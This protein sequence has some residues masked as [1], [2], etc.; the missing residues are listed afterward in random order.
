MAPTPPPRN[1][2]AKKVRLFKPLFCHFYIPALG[3][4]GEC[5]VSVAYSDGLSE[6]IE[7]LAAGLAVFCLAQ[8]GDDGGAAFDCHLDFKGDLLTA[9]NERLSHGEGVSGF[10]FTWH[11]TDFC[12]HGRE[13]HVGEYDAGAVRIPGRDFAVL[14]EP[15]S[16]ALAGG[17]AVEASVGFYSVELYFVFN[18]GAL[19]AENTCDFA[20][21]QVECYGRIVVAYRECRFERDFLDGDFS[22]AA[23]TCHCRRAGRGLG[24]VL[25]DA[26]RERISGGSDVGNLET[27]LGAVIPADSGVGII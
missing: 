16:G 24:T 14:V 17:V 27:R 10:D 13:V 18:F 8:V 21:V 15:V 2:N 3:Q 9:V 11:V 6:H 1:L 26:E 12:G 20:A 19:D 4:I 23:G 5:S 7:Y 25:T 22:D